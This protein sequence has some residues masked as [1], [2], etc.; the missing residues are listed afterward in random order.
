[1]HP[2]PRA[3]TLL[4]P[5]LHCSTPTVYARW[6]EL[7]GPSG[8]HGNDLEPAALAAYPELA[9]WRDLLGEATGQQP[10]LAGS[11]A[12]WFLR[13]KHDVADAL[14]DATVIVTRSL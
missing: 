7:G 4:T 1:M 11:G 5:P 9:R 3:L 10:R 2:E 14:S 8:E 13:G 12:T 6:D